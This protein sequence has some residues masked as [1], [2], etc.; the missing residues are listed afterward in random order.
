MVAACDGCMYGSY[1][2]MTIS[3]RFL[4]ATLD[5]VKLFLTAPPPKPWPVSHERMLGLAESLR[6]PV[7]DARRSLSVLS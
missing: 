4:S 5:R 6:P 7:P 2:E 3:M 1:P